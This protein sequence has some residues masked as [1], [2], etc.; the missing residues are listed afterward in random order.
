[1]NSL[2]SYFSST[3][4]AP[5]EQK[6]DDFRIK[7]EIEAKIRVEMEAKIRVEMEAKMRSEMEVKM[8][9]EMEAKA[10]EEH[11]K[12]CAEQELKQIY[13]VRTQ[14]IIDKIKSDSNC[15]SLRN[16]LQDVWFP[17]LD[18]VPLFM[19]YWCYDHS[20]IRY[21]PSIFITSTDVYLCFPGNGS[22]PNHVRKIYSFT[23]PV[24]EKGLYLLDHLAD[25]DRGC[26]YGSILSRAFGDNQRYEASLGVRRKF[27][28]V[29]RLI[30][31][32]YKNGLWKQLDGFFGMYFNEETM[33]L[34]EVPPSS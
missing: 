1:M 25:Q 13:N 31:G 10:K 20:S 29:I 11:Q 8:R 5:S 15:G 9:S 7:S 34:S 27:E 28:S 14:K 23:E 19:E 4:S 24:G 32:S 30:P 2:H 12:F 26:G 16:E 6:Y 33:E 21:S 22:I 3:P 18:G 17:L